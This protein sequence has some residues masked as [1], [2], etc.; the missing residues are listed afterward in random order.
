MT[1]C[2][3]SKAR[4]QSDCISLTVLR[5][6]STQRAKKSLAELEKYFPWP[7]FWTFQ[8][9]FYVKIIFVYAE[10]VLIAAITTFLASIILI[11]GVRKN[12]SGMI[13]PWII[14]NIV[15]TLGGMSIFVIKIASYKTQVNPA[16][17]TAT[18]CYFI[19]TI[20][21]II[22][23]NAYYRALRRQKRLA[24][25][26]LKSNSTLDSSGKPQLD[27]NACFLAVVKIKIWIEKS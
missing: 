12:S 2:K 27:I 20:Y 11:F 10:I 23:V 9:D 26:V 19:L 16:K 5:P 4:S 1:P 25:Q 22:S 6:F 18:V 15:D 17:V 14:I 7:L 24:L 21:F 13:L 3:I 8:Y